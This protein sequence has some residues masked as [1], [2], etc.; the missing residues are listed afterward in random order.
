MSLIFSRYFGSALRANGKFVSLHG[1]LDPFDDL[2]VCQP[3]PSPDKVGQQVFNVE[4]ERLSVSK[5]RQY[6]STWSNDPKT[7]ISYPGKAS[8]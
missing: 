5:T 4:R 7:M 6:V 2:V 3:N 8:A 1:L